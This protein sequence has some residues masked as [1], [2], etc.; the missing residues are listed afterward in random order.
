MSSVFRVEELNLPPVSAAFLLA[1][2]FDP[3][4]G[5]NMFLLNVS[6]SPDDAVL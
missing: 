1:L 5:G 2:L 3:E 6:L 4:D